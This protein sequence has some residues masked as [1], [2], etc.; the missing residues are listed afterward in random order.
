M[1]ILVLGSGGREHALAWKIAQSPLTEKLYIAP[2]N[3]GTAAIGQNVILDAADHAAVVPFCSDKNIGLVVVGSDE[4]LAAGIIDALTGAGVTAFGP[5]KAAAELEWSKSYAKQVMQEDGIPTA[6]YQVFDTAEDAKE[7]AKAQPLP[8]V[9]KADGLALGKGVVIAQT[10]EEAQEAIEEMMG[11][12]V[13]GDAGSRIV[14]EEF[15]EGFEISAHAIC[16]GERA[17]MFPSSKDHKRV[18]EGDTG[19]N[20]GGMGTIA[21]VPGVSSEDMARIEERIVLP[22]LRG[23]K[24][25]G[26]EFRGLLFPGIM[27]TTDGPKVIEFNARFGDPETESYMRLLE[28]DIVPALYA[29][30]KGDVSETKLRWREGTAA[31]IAVA[32]LG[33]PGAYEKGKT[34]AG[35]KDAE[36]LGAV[37]FHAGTKEKDGTLETSGGRVLHAT[38]TGETLPD[39]LQNAYAAAKLITFDG[40]YYRTDIGKSARG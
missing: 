33:Y 3:P 36:M 11:K 34:I 24:K 8:L 16:D 40:A 30:A 27:L 22:L 14:I 21:P 19:P 23:M 28:S 20:T 1:N 29:S 10:H 13:H 38:A 7:Y 2:G 18:G 5:T 31:S 12:K 35:I 37:V 26:K 6:R 25:R 15:L 17:L 9:I 4:P 32:S 39:A